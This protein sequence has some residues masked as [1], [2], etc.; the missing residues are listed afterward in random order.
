MPTRD[1]LAGETKQAV[2]SIVNFGWKISIVKA[3]AVFIKNAASYI[4][5]MF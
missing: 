1:R 4:V 5:P 2:S 3:K